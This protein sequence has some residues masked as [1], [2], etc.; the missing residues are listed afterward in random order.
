MSDRYGADLSTPYQVNQNQAVWN[1]NLTASTPFFT[2]LFL[3]K[4]VSNRVSII[5]FNYMS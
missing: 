1:P 2:D 3:K 4:N 5:I